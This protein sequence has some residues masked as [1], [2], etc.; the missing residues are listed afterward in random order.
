MAE[1]PRDPHPDET[2]SADDL[3]ISRRDALALGSGMLILGSGLAVMTSPAPAVAGTSSLALSFFRKAGA[4]FS[5]I[6]SITLPA[7]LV[8]K[9]RAADLEHV[10]VSWHR[11]A[12]EQ[13]V[14]LAEHALPAARQ[15]K[16]ALSKKS[17]K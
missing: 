8:A 2:P 16:S 7:T 14:R 10:Q 11:K 12:G 3:R 15:L 1:R 9:L 6:G 5:P 13:K 4:G 17:P